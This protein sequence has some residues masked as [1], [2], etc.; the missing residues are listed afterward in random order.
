[1]PDLGQDSVRRHRLVERTLHRVERILLARQDGELEQAAVLFGERSLR[2]GGM[3]APAGVASARTVIRFW[4]SVPVLSTH[5][6]VVAPNV[7]STAGIRRLSTLLREILHAPSARRRSG[8]PGTPLAGSPSPWRPQRGGPASR[9]PAPPP[10]VSANVRLVLP[11]VDARRPT[12]ASAPRKLRQNGGRPKRRPRSARIS[13]S[14]F[15]ASS[16]G[17]RN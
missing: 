17:D 4:V 9:P 2:R 13:S 1:M 10:R 15:A 12:A 6:T 7:V 11:L 3:T 5:S 14:N 16:R 8:P